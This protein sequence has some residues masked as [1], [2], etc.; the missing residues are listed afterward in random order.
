MFRNLRRK[1]PTGTGST[2]APRVH[3]TM[4]GMRVQPDVRRVAATA[5][6][7]VAGA[8]LRWAVT[9]AA[10]AT[11]LPWPVLLVNAAGCALL[12]YLV[13]VAQERPAQ[14][15]LLHDGAGVGFCGGLTTYSS[16]AVAVVQEV[17]G[18]EA[19]VALSN[20]AASVAVGL[21]CVAAGAAAARRRSPVG[22]RS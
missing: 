9:A 14:R 18:G 2:A 12:G 19:L 5:V 22:G 17:R 21:V 1:R 6:G 20:V 4:Q 3:A 7:G 8:G 11:R 16:F 15:W 13:V 10:G